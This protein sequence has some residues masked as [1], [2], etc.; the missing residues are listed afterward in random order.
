M[1][2]YEDVDH[3]RPFFWGQTVYLVLFD[4]AFVDDDFD[5][6]IAAIGCLVLTVAHADKTVAVAAGQSFGSV[7]ARFEGFQHFHV[8]FQDCGSYNLDSW[9][10][11]K[12]RI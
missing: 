10:V 1:A 4:G 9:K 8:R 12:G 6:G 3:Q 11:I 2:G 7:I 5:G